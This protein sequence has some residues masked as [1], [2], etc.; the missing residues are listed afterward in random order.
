MAFKEISAV[1]RASAAL[2]AAGA[3]EVGQAFVCNTYLELTFGLTYT[4]GGA[5]GAVTYF[6]EFSFNGIDFFRVGE[7]Q[8]AAIVA[9]SNVTV[10]EQAA[11]LLYTAASASAES[12][13]SPTF[14][15]A[16]K[17]ARISAQESGNTG[18]PGTLQVQSYLRGDF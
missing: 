9:G 2:P 14:T 3:V 4:R 11:N 18:A 1:N 16:G 13:L 7:F 5:S 17:W 8:A 12:F 15:V 10:S 6:V